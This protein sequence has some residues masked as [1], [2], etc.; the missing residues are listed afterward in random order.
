MAPPVVLGVD[1]SGTGAWAGPATVTGV[2]FYRDQH[3][4]GLKDSK[5]LSDKQR[6]ALIA[7]IADFGIYTFTV[8]LEPRIINSLGLRVA[9]RRGIIDVLAGIV[10]IKV[11]DAIFVDGA[12]DKSLSKKYSNIQFVVR[13]DETIPCVSAASILAKTLRNDRMNELAKIYPQYGFDKHAGYG[14]AEHREA[15]RKYGICP[16]HRDVKPLRFDRK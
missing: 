14:T 10:K 6:R 4:K 15:I 11:P 1:E 13:G 12:I 16:Q 5:Q 9:W 3:P 8:F 2:L 7:P